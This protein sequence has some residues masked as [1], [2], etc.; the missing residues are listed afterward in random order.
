MSQIQNISSQDVID[1]QWMAARYAHN[2]QSY[3]TGMVNDLTVKMIQNG[4][5]PLPDQTR[6]APEPT[7][8]VK[9]S[10]FGWPENLIEKYG[11]DGRKNRETK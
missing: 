5:Y 9:D 8:W 2:R 11:W 6:E 7:V 1:L 3:S 4:I 10:M